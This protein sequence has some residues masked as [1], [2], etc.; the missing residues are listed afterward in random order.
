M[1]NLIFVGEIEILT[2]MKMKKRRRGWLLAITFFAFLGSS[3]ATQTGE[4]RLW[5]ASPAAKW[6]EAL[7]LGNGRLGAMVYGQALAEHYQ[8]N[9]STLWSGMPRSGNNPEARIAL[10]SVREAVDRG[11]YELAGKLWKEYAQ[12]PYSARYLP[13]GDLHILMDHIGKVSDYQRAL[14]L[15]TA[16]STVKY[17]MQGRKYERRTFI[18]YPAQLMVVHLT[19]DNASGQSFQVVL[20]SKLKG[21]T[22]V[23]GHG[24]L[25]FRGR[26]PAH[27][28]AREYDAMQVTYD[29]QMGMTFEIRVNVLGK[30]VDTS[31]R[32]DTLCVSGGKEITLLLA[33]ATSFQGPFTCPGLDISIPSNKNT[34]RMEAGLRHGYEALLA[35]HLKDY[36]QLY[37]RV[38][39]RLG[40]T[41]AAQ[42]RLPTGERIKAFAQ[43][44]HDGGLAELYF[45]YGRYLMIASSREGGVPSN[46]QGI[47]NDHIQPPWGSN[48]TLNINTEMNYWPVEVA[49][50]SE[51]FSPLS[52]F[53]QNLSLSGA[54]TAKVNYGLDNCWVVHHNSDVWCKSSPTGGYAADPKGD[55]RWS[56]WPMAGIWLC[57]SLWEHYAFTG[58]ETYLRQR[59][60]PLMEGAVNFALQWLQKDSTG[61]L[62]TNP[63]TSPE[64]RFYYTKD[65]KRIMGSV[66]KG[67]TMDMA[68]IRDLFTNY[69][70][71]AEALGL[72]DKIA[73]VKDALDHLFPYQ[74]GSQGQLLEWSR[75]FEEQDAQHR[76]ISHLFGLHPGKQILP[77]R[78][79]MLTDAVRKTLA[80]RGDGGTGWSMAWKINFWA[81]LEEGNHAYTML[82]KALNF[83]SATEVSTKGGGVYPNLF[84]AHPP[85]QIDGNFGGTAGIAEMLVQSHAGYI[86]LLPALPDE[87]SSG[88]VTGLKTRGG[89]VI[90]MK[91]RNKK[92]TFLQVTSTLG[93]ICRL[94]SSSRFK[95]PGAPVSAENKLMFE[96]PSPTVM[97]PQGATRATQLDMSGLSE[98]TLNTVKGKKYILPILP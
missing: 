20:N 3:A 98:T 96:C 92:I 48:Y 47:W 53:V 89:F 30:N 16:L 91:W 85:F 24:T 84:D 71:G 11:D 74:I 54:Q 29:D 69:I 22:T 37:S 25:L 65:G 93:G 90:D 31:F 50:L 27:V 2:T 12:G 15:E 78:D 7:P 6:E 62:Q 38:S 40:K 8:L 80:I 33:A 58:D 46:L 76:H 56:C 4:H 82:R 68:M 35:D 57:Q 19:T 1:L 43:G 70:Q 81:R 72:H 86:H 97:T 21:E 59:A 60:F 39:L 18:S 26:A 23:D 64:N 75:E 61:Y 32:G 79:K 55:P 95:N 66:S 45:Q 9:E 77:R 51:C 83:V 5:Y 88:H 49:N 36:Q 41:T 10:G 44:G 67:T 52:D 34:H 63:S 28:A 73:R 17:K 42:R 14:D 13:L 87:W 94:V